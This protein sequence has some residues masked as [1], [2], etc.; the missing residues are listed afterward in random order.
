MGNLRNLP[1]GKLFDLLPVQVLGLGLA[2]GLLALAP[3]A[4]AKPRLK[5]NGHITSGDFGGAGVLQTRTAR[6]KADGMLEVGYSF[7]DPYKR[8][9][10]TV[11]ALPWLSGAFRY[12]AFQNHLFSEGGLDAGGQSFKD[13]G[14]DLAFRISKEGRYIPEISLVLQDGLGTGQF[15]S[16]HL[17]ASKRFYDFDFGFG[18][19]WG[20]GTSGSSIK[21]PFKSISPKFATRG[22][23]A[24]RGGQVNITNYFSGESIAFFGNASWNTPIKGLVL[25]AEYDPNNFENEPLSFDLN[26]YNVNSSFNFGFEYS[27]FPWLE[28]SLAHERGDATLLRVTM[29]SNLHSSG[30]PKFDPPPPP[31]NARP[32]LVKQAVVGDSLTENMSNIGAK[33]KK[34]VGNNAVKHQ[35][36]VSDTLVDNVAAEGMEY[37]GFELSDGRATVEVSVNSGS[38]FSEGVERIAKLV[39]DSMPASVE[40]VSINI[41]DDLKG[42]VSQSS[43]MRREMEIT[44]IVDYL[45]DELEASGFRLLEVGF[46]EATAELTLA[47]SMPTPILT[48]AQAARLVLRTLPTPVQAV[49]ITVGGD[50]E[51]NKQLTVMR[52]EVVREADVDDLFESFVARGLTIEALEISKKT[53]TIQISVPLAEHTT[54]YHMIA[55]LTEQYLPV[56]INQVTF[57]VTQGGAELKRFSLKRTGSEN[58]SWSENLM[59]GASGTE[60]GDDIHGPKYSE[61]LKKEISSKLF[62]ALRKEKFVADGMILEGQSV[63]VYGVP[64]AFRQYARSLGR[65]IRVTANHMPEEVE[66]I[67]I[68]TMNA[69][70]ELA[71]ITVFRADIEAAEVDLGSVEEIWSKASIIGVDGTFSLP[72]KTTR[73]QQRYPSFNWSLAPRLRGHVGGPDQFVLHQLWASL[74]AQVEFWRGFSVAGNLGQNIENNFDK[75]TLDSDSSLP[76]VRSDVKEYLQQGQSNLVSLHADYIFSPA[77][78]FFARVSAGYFEEMYGGF[79]AELLHRPFGSRLAVGLEVN[80]VWQ[81]DFDQRLT[82]KDYNIVTGHLSIYYDMPWYD[83]LGSA[84]IGQYLAGD[85]GVTYNISRAFDS[86]VR[87]GLWAT[88]TD[89]SAEDFGEGSFD[90]G[91]FVSLPFEMFLTKSSTR[92]GTFAF[93]PLSRDG[94]QMVSVK[95]RLYGLTG[96]SSPQEVNRDWNRILD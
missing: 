13:R 5:P 73:N 93:R 67:S 15:A 37:L 94:G 4:I 57:V 2:L 14:A 18:V 8:Y 16:E 36:Q 52:S 11:Q 32:K 41:R 24:K 17:V 30:L 43:Y 75:I 76:R 77:K 9:Y 72:D 59:N 61:K 19:I 81:R 46:S 20:Y 91:F 56:A 70:L 83:L 21:N 38:D 85:K 51:V 1:A 25:K 22:P 66:E 62:A 39:M 74:S 34:P 27:P 26:R 95:N 96:S 45:F 69:G 71:R 84:H 90:K 7:V 50:S 33:L 82:F 88:L 55:E 40:Q 65:A 89:V 58:I 86:G 3:N 23:G 12:T 63:T 80:K 49:T 79:S 31:I 6:A 47:K 87:V 92:G 42:T 60:K 68:V 48:I 29:R 10:I 53:A 44:E 78:E 28:L 54:D 64:R 35:V